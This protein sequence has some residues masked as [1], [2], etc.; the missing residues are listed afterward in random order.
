MNGE[1]GGPIGYNSEAKDLAK[2][3]N[4]AR[5]KW[6]P[7]LSIGPHSQCSGCRDQYVKCVCHHYVL[8]I[9]LIAMSE[10]IVL[11]VMQKPQPL[12][13]SASRAVSS[14]SK[15]QSGDTLYWVYRVHCTLSIYRNPVS[16]HHHNCL[17]TASNNGWNFIQPNLT[18]SKLLLNSKQD[19]VGPYQTISD[20]IRQYQTMSDNIWQYLTISQTISNNIWQYQT[21]SDN[22]GQ[23]NYHPILQRLLAAPRAVDWSG[24]GFFSDTSSPISAQSTS[25]M[26]TGAC[27][28]A[29]ATVTVWSWVH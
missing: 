15:S 28:L 16:T 5:T 21:I 2:E 23:P 1:G 13:F 18:V 9:Y 7:H 12:Q 25:V 4:G 17:S 14:S 19:N 20:N 8:H 3:E 24:W 27:A 11:T 10:K 22:I 26:K 29:C 6:R